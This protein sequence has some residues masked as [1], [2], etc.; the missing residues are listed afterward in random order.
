MTFANSEK[1]QFKKMCI[2]ISPRGGNPDRYREGGRQKN[3]N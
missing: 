2:K 1:T 3:K